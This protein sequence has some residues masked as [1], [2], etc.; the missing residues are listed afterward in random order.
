MPGPLEGIRV[1]DF[2]Q[3]LAGPF[4]P[5]LLADLGAEVIKV[6]SIH[7]DGMRHRNVGPFLGCQ[8]GKRDIVLDL[9]KP[10]GLAIA[11]RLVATADVVHHNMQKGIADRLGIGHEHCKAVRPDILYCNTYMYGPVGP[12]SHLGGLDPLGQAASGIEWEQGPVPEGNP[13]LWYRYGHGDIAAAIPSVFGVLVALF[14]RGGTGV[15]QSVWTS[16]LH[17]SMLHTA[18]SWLAADGTPSPRG[19]LDREQLGLGALYRLYETRDGWLQ[20]AAV[21]P[22]HWPALCAV[23]GRAELA[24]DPRF[25]TPDAREERRA[26]LTALLAEAFRADRAL[27]WVRALDAAGVPAEISADTRDGETLLFDEDLVRL[28]L[29]TEHTHPLLGRVRQF[30]NLMT[31]SDTPTRPDRPAPLYGQHTREIL[32]ELGYDEAAIDDLHA[33]GAV[34]SCPDNY[35]YPV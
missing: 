19:T 25:A 18:D 11:L 22:E 21:R 20:L 34:A 14:H 31:F 27:A 15:S 16:I 6:E 24:S 28:G 7:G 12:Y 35:P 5:M 32:T 1:I 13:P 3:F 33:R 26:E 10:E 17:G 23:L 9:K 30:G 4:G 2:G 8:R 29:V